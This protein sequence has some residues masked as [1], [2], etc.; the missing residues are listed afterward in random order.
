MLESEESAIRRGAKIYAEVKG[1]HTCSVADNIY[2][3]NK[4]GLQKVL[5]NVIIQAG[6]HPSEVDMING[7]ATATK[8][9][10]PVEAEAIKS[11]LATPYLSMLR[12]EKFEEKSLYDKSNLKNTVITAYK[13]HMGHLNLASGATETAFIIKAM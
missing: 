9:G 11:V 8:I 12:D 2:K 7:H 13:G 3:P 10:D 1:F 6:W 5:S 4:L